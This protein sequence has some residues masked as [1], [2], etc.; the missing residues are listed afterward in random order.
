MVQP[1]KLSA[2]WKAACIAPW[3]AGSFSL[4]EPAKAAE[5]VTGSYLLGAAIPMSGFTPPPGFY[6]SDMIYAYHGDISG[7]VKLPFGNFTLSG[8]IKAD[9]LINLSTVSW[10]TARVRSSGQSIPLPSR[11]AADDTGPKKTLWLWS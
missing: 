10:I 5:Y 9:F 8:N 3:L 11:C 1:M 6:L 4:F 7:N 2:P